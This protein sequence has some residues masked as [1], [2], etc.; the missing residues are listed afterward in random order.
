M[1]KEYYNLSELSI[2]HLT[3]LELRQ[4]KK[5][6][7]QVSKSIKDIRL[8]SKVKNKWNIH[9]SILNL[10]QRERKRG[11]K[12]QTEVT[13]HLETG[14][15]KNY[16]HQLANDIYNDKPNNNF[17]FSIEI[18]TNNS[19]HLHIATQ[20]TAKQITSSIKRIERKYNVTILKNKHTHIAPI[21]D[22]EDYLNYIS[23]QGTPITLH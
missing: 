11:Q 8:I 16:Y 21:Y 12:Y 9:Y 15:D 10:F 20:R 18:D 7:K 5:R 13:I 4:L 17:C 2:N 1:L 22:L 19:A 3:N 23:K 14:Y 6:V